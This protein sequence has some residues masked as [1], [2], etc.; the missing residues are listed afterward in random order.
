MTVDSRGFFLK[1]NLVKYAVDVSKFQEK[2]KSVWLS[3]L[4]KLVTLTNNGE[5][6]W[7]R[8][9]SWDNLTTP[10]SSTWKALLLN[11][12][13]SF[14]WQGQFGSHWEMRVVGFFFFFFFFCLYRPSWE[15][16]DGTDPLIANRRK[17]AQDKSLILLS[18]I[19]GFMVSIDILSVGSL[20]K[21]CREN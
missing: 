19:N 4:W 6:S 8:P 21:I 13:R 10:I 7:V 17:S 2:E 15:V 20:W 1:G 18:A 5:T 11:V 12:S 14:S 3:R 16:T 9:A